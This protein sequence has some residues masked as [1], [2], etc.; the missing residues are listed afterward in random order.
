MTQHSNQQRFG[1]V[2]AGNMGG[3][4]AQKMATEGFEVVLVDV[5]EAKAK[6]GFDTIRKTLA[7]GVDRGVF[8]PDQVAQI[9]A[10]IHASGDWQALAG[11]TLIVEAV[12]ENFDIKKQVFKRLEEICPANTILGTNTSSFSV[13][14]LQAGAKHPQRI[15]GL[16]YF[17]HP[18]MNRLVEVVPGRQTDPAVT[19]RAWA[20]QEQLGKTPITSADAY[21]FIVNRFFLQWLN[22]AIRMLEENFA[23]IATID[24]AAMQGFGV[25][26][27]PFKLMNVSGVPIAMHVGNT[28]A[29]AFG[30][31]YGPPPL[32]VKQ[33]E[34]GQNW[35]LGGTIDEGKFTSVNERLMGAVFHAAA[36]LVDAGIGSLDDTD[37]GARVGLRWRE[38]PFALMN[39]MGPRQAAAL[40]RP[41]AQRWGLTM[42][43]IVEKHAASATPFPYLFVRKDIQDGIAT[44][45][46]NRPDTLNAINEEVVRQL[47]AAFTEVIANPSVRGIVLAG[48]GKAFIAGAD[49]QVFIRNIEQR[50]IDK[51]VAF[52]RRGQE[53]LHLIETSPKPIVARLHGLALGGGFEIAL[54]CHHIVASEKVSMA[55][56]ETGIG[57]YPGLGGT[58]RTSRRVGVGLAKFLVFTG[59]MVSAADAAEMGLIDRAVPQAEL[60]T[61]VREALR[62]GVVSARKLKPCPAKYQAVAERFAKASADELLA[63]NPVEEKDGLCQKALQ[64]LA[65]KA[66]LAV[67]MAG[68]LIEQG[69]GLPLDRGLDLELQHLVEMFST[70]DA[71]VGLKSIGGAAPVFEGR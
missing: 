29:A 52:T 42:P 64:R 61:A 11:T 1:V 21:G 39:R 27:G 12:F 36:Q 41:I 4:I 55:F 60:D 37:L 48:S 69:A 58:Q 2:G 59:Q 15:L 44:L 70:H 28:L 6:N 54:A 34:S 62:Q 32:L 16:H 13:T 24:A 50:Q 45:T 8:K 14:E 46:V 38:G 31:F 47:H 40:M 71:Y 18:A 3:G 7:Q 9:L 57:I 67:R 20:I 17:Y 22:E 56:P 51:T 19:A 5:D 43:A 23:D 35:T 26:M 53:L 30:P 63:A 65:T 33:V 68:R 49:I 66:P 10:R 25:S